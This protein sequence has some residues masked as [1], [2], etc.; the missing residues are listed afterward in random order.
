MDRLGGYKG[1]DGIARTLKCCSVFAFGATL[2][3]IGAT[4]VPAGP[5]A[6]PL[7]LVLLALTLFFG[8]AIM[9]SATGIL[10]A[11]VPPEL[12]QLSSA[13]AAFLFQVRCE[14]HACTATE[15]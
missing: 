13:G 2:S 11:T 3:A 1:K 12:R 7:L 4:L 15:T 14:W 9:P 6:F 8:G 5:A 10:Q